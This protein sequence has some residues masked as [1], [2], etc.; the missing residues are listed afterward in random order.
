MPVLSKLTE[1]FRRYAN[2]VSAHPQRMSE[3]E[4]RIRL[5]GMLISSQFS[6]RYLASELCFMFN[7]MFMLVN[8][9]ILCRERLKSP[10]FPFKLG[11]YLIEN[12]ECIVEMV[13]SKKYG[14]REKWIAVTYLQ[15]M[16]TCLRLLLLLK[17]K[18]YL[19]PSPSIEQIDRNLLDDDDFSLPFGQRNPFSQHFDR[20]LNGRCLESWSQKNDFAEVLYIIKPLVHLAALKKYGL[21]SWRPWILSLLI[22]CIS[23][24]MSARVSCSK[25]KQ[26]EKVR[27]ALVLSIYLMKS[28]FFDV[29]TKH[30]LDHFLNSLQSIPYL[31]SLALWSKKSITEYQEIYFYLWKR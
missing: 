4:C 9:S 7:N 17:F 18:S 30:Y 20:T 8:D 19:L 22:D 26:E 31:S 29:Y 21:R 6:Q 14:T 12:F 23:S 5:V 28:P 24:L 10:K 11:I 16:K 3:M 1:A 27:R 15:I 25:Q 2:Y 13:I